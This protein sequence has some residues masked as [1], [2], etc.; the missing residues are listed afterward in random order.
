MGPRGELPP[1]GGLK[2]AAR[3]ATGRQSRISSRRLLRSG[4]RPRARATLEEAIDVRLDLRNAL[5]ALGEMTLILETLQ[6][7]ERLA[8]R[9]G[10]RAR[11]GKVRLQ[12]FN[13]HF[14]LGEHERRSKSASRRSRLLARSVIGRL[15][16]SHDPPER[17]IFAIGDYSAPSTSSARAWRCWPTSEHECWAAGPP[18]VVSRSLLATALAELGRLGEALASPRRRLAEAADHPFTKSLAY[19][20]G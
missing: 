1:P 14:F 3:A 2:A 12:I 16:S 5:L 9:L 17:S 7:A 4:I 20:S 18:A 6:E 10:D 11:S 13:H 15:K 8:E 19:C